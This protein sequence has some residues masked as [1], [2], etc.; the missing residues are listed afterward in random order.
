M[1]LTKL[2]KA[3]VIGTILSA[4]KEKE[5]KEYVDLDKLPPLI[6]EIESMSDNITRTVKK[7]TD[8]ILINKLIDSFLEEINQEQ[9]EPIPPIKK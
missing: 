3:I 5:F 7:E 9:K 4:I 8:K 1:E 6:K 2:E